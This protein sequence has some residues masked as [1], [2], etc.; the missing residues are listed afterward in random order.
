MANEKSPA[1]NALEAEQA[2]QRSA[3]ALDEGLEDTFP[4]SDPVS[5]TTTAIPSGTGL[6]VKSDAPHVDE[7]LQSILEHRDDPYVEPREHL[8]ALRDEAESLQYRAADNVRDRI[9]RNPWQ[10]IG[11][12]AAVGFIVGITR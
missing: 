11:L 12:A 4:A 6:S 10:A 1:V 9:R 7:A 3:G 8:A 5:A 2:Q